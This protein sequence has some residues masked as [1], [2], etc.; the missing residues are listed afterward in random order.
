MKGNKYRM[1]KWYTVIMVLGL[2]AG[3]GCFLEA[4]G[5]YR[6]NEEGVT[7]SNGADVSRMLEAYVRRVVDGDTIVVEIEN[8]PSPLRKEERV[9]LLGVD[10]PETVDP[11]RPVER[12]GKEASRLTKETLEKETVYLAF[13]WDLRDRYG[14]LLAYVYL[15]KGR[16][17]N[18][19]LI[20]LGY[21]HAYLQYPFQFIE[22]FRDYEKTA[23][24]K[25]LGL[26]GKQ[27]TLTVKNGTQINAMIN[28]RRKGMKAYLYRIDGSIIETP[29]KGFNMREK[30]YVDL[31]MPETAGE[32]EVIHR[33]GKA[34]TSAV[35]I[36]D[37][38]GKMITGEFCVNGRM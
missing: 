24:T 38:T 32:H 9:R 2:L 21:G 20:G 6:V 30:L 19:M 18:A 13:D 12:F 8:P 27:P 1:K 14:R 3:P 4:E 22:E 16:C 5:L 11:R 15:G 29:C 35:I 31:R 7:A 23:R 33:Y 36:K 34:T 17:Y 25:K 28:K 10:T 37:D 26:W